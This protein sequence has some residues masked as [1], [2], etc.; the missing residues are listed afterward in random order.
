M[1]R[2]FIGF[3]GRLP[4]ECPPRPAL[5]ASGAYGRAGAFLGA[6]SQRC[7]GRYIFRQLEDHVRWHFG[8]DWIA[9]GERKGDSLQESPWRVYQHRLRTAPHH[10]S[11]IRNKKHPF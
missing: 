6:P 5:R 4:P 10:Q 9:S 1:C 2:G 11:G 8:L 7:L 3:S